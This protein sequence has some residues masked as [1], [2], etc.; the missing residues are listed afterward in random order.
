MGLLKFELGTQKSI[1]G[2][3]LNVLWRF[4]GPQAFE[5]DV[6]QSRLQ[7]VAHWLMTQGLARLELDT[8]E[9]GHMIYRPLNQQLRHRWGR[10]VEGFFSDFGER[11]KERLK[12]AFSEPYIRTFLELYP[13]RF[14][15]VHVAAFCRRHFSIPYPDIDICVPGWK[16]YYA[17]HRHVGEQFL[18]NIRKTFPHP[19]QECAR[20]ALIME[21]ATRWFA[22]NPVTFSRD[23]WYRLP[24]QTAAW[25]CVCCFSA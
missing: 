3:I 24:D 10:N 6:Q 12:E 9:R 2:E 4:N 17:M 21:D 7:Q 18:E 25:L 1:H 5:E 19:L 15:G 14:F 16:G 11:E 22:G 13:P 20:E 8:P 23:A